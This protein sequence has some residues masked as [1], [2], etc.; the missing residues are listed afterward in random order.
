[1]SRRGADTPK[2]A[3]QKKRGKCLNLRYNVNK[4]HEE[5]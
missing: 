4:L 3:A 5:K 2:L 1:M